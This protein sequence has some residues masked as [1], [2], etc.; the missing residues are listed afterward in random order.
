MRQPHTF[1]CPWRTESPGTWQL[2]QDTVPTLW[3]AAFLTNLV[4]GLH[5][6]DGGSTERLGAGGCERIVGSPGWDIILWKLKIQSQLLSRRVIGSGF[7]FFSFYFSQF[8]KPGGLLSVFPECFITATFNGCDLS[9]RKV[10]HQRRWMWGLLVTMPC[11]THSASLWAPGSHCPV[12]GLGREVK[13]SL[14]SWDNLFWGLEKHLVC[15]WMCFVN[16]SIR[17]LSFSL[18]VLTGA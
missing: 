3:C 18:A 4:S 5:R 8:G 11:L 6:G 15:L 14:P 7:F 2:S 9:L 10:E 13:T 1:T 16:F 12:I 17:I